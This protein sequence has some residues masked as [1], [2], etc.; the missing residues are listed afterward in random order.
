[1]SSPDYLDRLFG[2]AGKRAVVT[3]G[4]SGIGRAAGVALAGA[5]A[6]VI[7]GGRDAARAAEVVGEITAA[8]GTASFVLGELGSR[9]EVA[10]FAEGIQGRVDILVNCAGVFERA[11]GEETS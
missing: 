6:E 9:T 1:M 3:G 5:G 8:G 7:V 2:L 10:A 4:T 11:A